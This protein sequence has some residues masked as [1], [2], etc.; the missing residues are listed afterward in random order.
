M[1]ND[2]GDPNGNPEHNANGLHWSIDNWIH[3]A[4]Y[5]GQFRVAA[6]GKLTHRPAAIIGQWGVSSNEYG[7]IYRNSNEDPLRA[8][9][10]PSRPTRASSCATTTGTRTATQNTA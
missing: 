4:R 7:Q 9:L 3:N 10:I 2:Y 1:R 5:G 8:D 6:G